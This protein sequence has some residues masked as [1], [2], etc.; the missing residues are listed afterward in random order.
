MAV[1]VVAD[2]RFEPGLLDRG[3]EALRD[4]LRDTRGFDGCARVDVAQD[5][6][7]SARILLI[8]EWRAPEDHK[9][10]MAWRAES[11]TN[12]ALRE[13]LAQPP[14]ISYFE[15]RTDL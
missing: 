5:Q 12:R 1:T 2:L 10:Y 15:Q 3:L 4:M 13:A 6:S 11:G 8:E 14:S 7:D 9:A